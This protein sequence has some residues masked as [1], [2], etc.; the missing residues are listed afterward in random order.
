MNVNVFQLKFQT[1]IMHKQII[2]TGKFVV[3]D[4]E[5]QTKLKLKMA[6]KT[7]HTIFAV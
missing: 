7:L 4:P 6:I 2:T 3:Q 5:Q 1:K